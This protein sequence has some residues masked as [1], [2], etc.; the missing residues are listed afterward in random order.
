[1]RKCVVI[2]LVSAPGY[3]CFSFLVKNQWMA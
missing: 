3:P 1:M 2:M